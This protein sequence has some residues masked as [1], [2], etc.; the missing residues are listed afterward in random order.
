LCSSCCWRRDRRLI[1]G[2]DTKVAQFIVGA[3]SAGADFERTLMLG[4]QFLYP[5]GAALQRMFSL[6]QVTACPDAVLESGW[7]EPL[8]EALGARIVESIDASSF[9]GATLIHDMNAPVPHDWHGRYTLVFDGGTLEHVFNAPQAFKNCMDLLEVGGTFVQTV[10]ANNY[11]GHG[12][13]QFS[14]EL[15]FQL[16]SHANGFEVVAVVLR[17]DVNG[18]RSFA[19]TSPAAVRRRVQMTNPL[20]TLLCTIARKTHGVAHLSIPQQQDYEQSWRARANEAAYVSPPRSLR[21]S[22][23]GWARKTLPPA[24]ERWA[25][26]HFTP[27]PEAQ[28]DCFRRISDDEIVLGRFQ[29]ARQ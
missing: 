9:E 18:G 15:V 8:F 3:T 28:P 6:H 2:I 10:P 7:A 4:R 5:D 20:P 14:P 21:S 27:G 24:M 17:E 12:F 16:F 26:L 13:Y 19:V 29:F 25:R 1:L 11:M 23:T 22:L